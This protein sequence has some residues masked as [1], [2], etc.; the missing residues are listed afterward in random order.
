MRLSVKILI[1]TIRFKDKG[2]QRDLVESMQLFGNVAEIG[3]ALG[4]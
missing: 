2:V 1:W 3:D 4:A